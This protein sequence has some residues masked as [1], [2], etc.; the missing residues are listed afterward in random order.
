MVSIKY[1]YYVEATFGAAITHV[2]GVAVDGKDTSMGL[3]R[4]LASRLF[5]VQM[6][7]MRVNVTR[8]PGHT[9]VT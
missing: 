3:Q 4:R 1:Q 2:A 7:C 9:C 5:Q 8:S 6:N